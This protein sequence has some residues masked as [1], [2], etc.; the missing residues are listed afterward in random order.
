MHFVKM[1]MK[2][3]CDFHQIFRNL[4]ALQMFTCDQLQLLQQQIFVKEA[5][6]AVKA[7]IAKEA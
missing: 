2:Q 3:I 6:F 1:S 7:D 4:K 5:N